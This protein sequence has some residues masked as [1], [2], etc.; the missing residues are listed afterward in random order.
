MSVEFH[1]II[2]RPLVTEMAMYL[3]EARNT[4]AFAVDM[5]ATK[6]DIKR[7]I[8]AAFGVKVVKVRTM[9]MYGKPRRVGR[10]RGIVREQDWKKALVTLTEGDRIDLY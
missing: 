3:E 8:E 6:Q 9:R 10:S 4:Y 1:K 7:A 5:R 2:N